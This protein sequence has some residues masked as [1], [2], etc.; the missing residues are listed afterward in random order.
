MVLARDGGALPTMLPPFRFGLGGTLGDGSQYVG[1][2][3]LDDLI[4]VLLAC[5][6][7]DQLAGPVNTV[8]PNPITNRQL[9]KTLGKVLGRPT[10][11]PVPA[12]GVRLAFGNLADELLLASQRVVP[13]K[14]EQ[15]GFRW[16]FPNLEP[17]LRDL[18]DRP[19]HA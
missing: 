19:E 10:L 14:L 12:F 8:A 16:R 18:L 11:L 6:D 4:A 1:W 15:R 3:H 2:L 17:A 5:L 13:R 7:D 9:T